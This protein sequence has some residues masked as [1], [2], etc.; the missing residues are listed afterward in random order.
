MRILALS[1]K[2][3]QD[4]LSNKIY[5]LVVVVQLFIILG[6][7]GLAFI[8]SMISDPNL[9]DQWQGSSAIKVGITEDLNGSALEKSLKS[10]NLNL[11]YFKTVQEG[12][13]A[14][15]TSM[16]AMI[17]LKNSKGD[18]GLDANTANVFY[19]VVASKITKALDSY[20][21]Q[22]KLSK[23]GLSTSQIAA[24]EN[25]V[26]LKEVPINANSTSPLALDSSYFVEIMYGFI[27]PFIVL[28][29]F[30]LASNIVTD[31]VVGEKERKTFEVLL[32]TPLSST[33]V[34][35]GKILPILLFSLV[36]SAAWILLLEL[37][38]VPIYHSLLLLVLLFFVGL[39][40]IG[41]GVIISMLVD[42]TK[43]AN[44]AITLLLFFA[45]FVLFVPLFMDIPS[46]Q[47]ILNLIP[48]IIMVRMTSTPVL[49]PL[50]IL[51]FLPSIAIAIAIFGLSVYFFKKEGAIRL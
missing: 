23:Q 30:F 10:Q 38:K 41:L 22:Q 13:N 4:I 17:Y 28:L 15:G 32:M 11:V 3:S 39:I 31:S 16:V 27:I 14:L 49:D 19:S 50:I 2:E 44:S 48:T 1:K 12:K 9:I 43:E 24:I 51:S 34:V 5:L 35:V 46:L 47:G 18:I 6:A 21:L 29:P 20:R 45:T 8:S 37:L 42:S 40:F 33:M 7:F 26:L 25:P 36:Q